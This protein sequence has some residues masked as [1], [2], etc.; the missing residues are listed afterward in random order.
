M[1]TVLF[2]LLIITLGTA[3][4]RREGALPATASAAGATRAV[5]GQAGALPLSFEPNDGQAGAGVRYVAHGSGF[6]ISL[7]ENDAVV[8]ILSGGG[9]DGAPA[10]TMRLRLVPVGGKRR[11]RLVGLGRLPGR[12]SYFLGA[13]SRRWLRDIPSY[14]KVEYRQV[15][16]G[17]DLVFHG[18]LP[19]G[20]ETPQTP[21]LEYDWLLAPRADPASI[22]ERL[23]GAR[24]LTV[25][26]RGE[27]II[28]LGHLELRQGPPAAFQADGGREGPIRC[29]YI[30]TGRD[31]V[32]LR[33][34]RYD[35][36]R[37]LV[38]DPT[39]L[40]SIYLGGSG[41]DYANAVAVD[42]AGSAYVT[43][44]T[45]SQDFPLVRPVQGRN[46]GGDSGADAF[47][48]KL[49]PAGTAL[50]YSTY[51]GGSQDEEGTGI[52]LDARGD[53]FVV[54]FT[55]SANFPRAGRLKLR[56]GG[57][58]NRGRQ[59]QGEA[60]VSELN[61]AGDR[62]LWSS[63]L[64]GS[65]TNW[66]GGVAVGGAGTVY[67][68]GSTTSRDFPTSHPLQGTNRGGT[69]AFVTKIDVRRATLVYST[70]LGGRGDDSGRAIAVDATGAA[71]VTGS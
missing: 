19:Q 43:G 62:L 46:G 61:P 55:E 64:G 17:I 29:R 2:G 63:C 23:Q 65:G 47:V 68:A 25:D 15:Y 52:A 3:P 71:Y 24:S 40:Y 38:I 10:A 16:P 34:G 42:R 14:G 57:R 37:P 4:W 70:Y 26:R 48:A 21:R 1:S 9:S 69:D 27:L 11:P 41:W 44:A 39:L 7:R 58:C 54:G 32:G 33:V 35:H 6:V 30:L 31:E 49:N 50:L 59:K 56:G 45:G 66:S 20:L 22:V 8:E 60:F 36:Q 53:A 13:D 5:F 51:L 28:S 18:S 12:S 67:V